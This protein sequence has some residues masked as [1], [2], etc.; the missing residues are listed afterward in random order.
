MNLTTID[1]IIMLVYFVFVLSIGFALK[2][3]M[4]T[5]TDFFLSGRSIP[6]WITGLAFISANLGAQEVIGMGASGAKYGIATSHFYWVGAIPAMVFVG[7]FM[8]PFYYGSRAR[9]VPEYLRLRFD[10]KTR[11]LNAISFAIMTIFS[12][13]ISMYAIA[14]LVQTLHVFDGPFQRLGISS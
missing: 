13:G 7:V 6:A 3:Y 8:M 10:E 11:G 14:K 4:K 2:R 1:W 5:S 12:S 9:S